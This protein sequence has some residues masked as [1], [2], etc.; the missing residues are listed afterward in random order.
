MNTNNLSTDQESKWM[1]MVAWAGPISWALALLI[2]WIVSQGPDG[3]WSGLA[4]MFL[5]AT[6]ILLIHIVGPIALLTVV[7]KRTL[8]RTRI[9]R[10][11]IWGLAYYGLVGTVVL[12]LQGPSEFLN[13]ASVLLNIFFKR[14]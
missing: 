3:G 11:A 1:L 10:P 13:D 5:S 7:I 6:A 8:R 2:V 9:G 4:A 14:N 12:W